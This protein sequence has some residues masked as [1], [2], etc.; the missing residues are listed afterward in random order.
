MTVIFLLVLVVLLLGGVPVAFSI[1]LSSLLGQLQSTGIQ[2]TSF[3]TRVIGSLNTDNMV[4]IPMFL[5][6][7]ALMNRGG[8]TRRLFKFCN[9]LVGWLPGGLCHVNIGASLI[10]AGMS[11]SSMA[12]LG[13][14]GTIEL[15]AMKDEGF[16]DEVSVAVTGCSS[17]LGP[18]IPPS[19]VL[20][21]YGSLT[22]TSIGA[23]FM[24]GLVPGIVMALFMMG[25]VL[26]LDRKYH[27]PRHPRPKLKT[28][29]KD[30]LDAIPSLMT[31]VIILVGIYTGLFTTNEAG[32]IAA[33]WAL[34]LSTVVYK[35]V[36]WKDVVGIVRDMVDQMGGI[37]LIMGFANVF[38]S[39]LM[40]ALI[41][42]TVASWLTSIISNKYLML[43]ALTVFLLICGCF[44]ETTSTMAILMP[45]L[46]PI[47]NL[48]AIS[49]VQFGI[50]FELA[51]G[52]GGM[53]PPFGMLIFMMQKISGMS[54]E[55]I[56]KAYVPWIILMTVCLLFIVFVPGISLLLPKLAGLGVG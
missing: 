2:L 51:F 12:D 10:F 47:L 38:G 23:L 46:T 4:C 43:L 28:V 37:T 41:P 48:H 16:P 55:R 14:L 42:Q 9:S 15:K 11:G 34:F 20:I 30:F 53:T 13:G 31:V 33:L 21:L 32:A 40:R 6:A 1:G 18:M 36:T 56:I 39:V 5:F 22:N 35:E 19:V 7:G 52:I 49:F 25:Y 3:A 45:I 24:A 27:F 44:L 17:L 26:I 54:S 29:W 50:I 8:V